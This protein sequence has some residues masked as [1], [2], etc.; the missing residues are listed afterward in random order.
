MTWRWLAGLAVVAFVGSAAAQNV[1]APPAQREQPPV[2]RSL[3]RFSSDAELMRYIRDVQRLSGYAGRADGYGVATGTPPP[4]SAAPPAPPPP[5]SAPAPADAAA[6]LSAAAPQQQA[7]SGEATSITN[8]Q[9]QGVDEGGIVK[10]VGRFLVVLQDGRLFV[11]DTRPGG[12]PGL[13]LT[14]RTNVYRSP[15]QDTWYDEL[16][17]S[18]NRVLVTGYSYREASSEITVF[19]I[20]D[21]GHL[22]RETTYY[23]SSNDYYDTENYSTRLVNGNLV[24][25]TPLDLTYVNTSAAMSWPLVRRWLRDGDRRAVTTAGRRLFDA[26]DIYKPV[27]M[28]RAPMVHSVSVC[29]LGEPR[30][31]DE[32]DCRTTAFVGPGQREFFVSTS[33]I[34]LWVT[35]NPWRDADANQPCPAAGAANADAFAVPATLYQVPLSGEPPRAMHTRGQPTNQMAMDASDAEFRALLGW[36][37]SRCNQSSEAQ[38][39]YFHAP[40]SALSTTPQDAPARSYTAT[41]SVPTANY[42]VRFTG[43][44]VVYGGRSQ[45]GSYP[46]GENR[47]PQSARVVAVPVTRPSAAIELDA[48]HDI[49]RIERT[50]SNIV[51]TG[52]RDDDGLSISNLDLRSRP[53]LSDTQVLSGRFESENRSHAFNSLIGQDGSGLM[54]LATVTRV[55]ESGRWVWR[56]DSSDVSFLSVNAAGQLHGLGELSSRRGAVDPSYHCEVSCVDWY[57]NTRALYIGNRVFAL[58]GT[59]L[60]EGS[61]EDGRI[62]ERVR[63]NL[64]ARPQ[65]VSSRD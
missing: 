20:D 3:E 33:D 15:G 18:G 24:I 48:P 19:T 65:L 43:T 51:L 57:G 64:S 41:P 49:L 63:L 10:M 16:L 54:G 42:E 35:P 46:P 61:V 55:K 7:Q 23:I 50:G 17:I 56:S 4:Q 47:A 13:S 25:Y 62:S 27:Q 44:H 53:H 5:A 37:T 40:F 39:R 52:Y 31:G 12:A 32:L 9:T 36:N 22:T 28:T 11:V 59:E 8:V 34:Y 21:N 6:N 14:G 30:S 60:I 45:Y 26:Q 38:I 2:W 29:P 1:K 58:S